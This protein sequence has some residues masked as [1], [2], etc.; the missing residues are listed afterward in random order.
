MSGRSD[1][2]DGLAGGDAH[3][4]G[5]RMRAHGTARWCR[6]SGCARV[7]VAFPQ[8]TPTRWTTAIAFSVMAGF[9]NPVMTKRDV[10]G[11]GI[12]LQD[13]DGPLGT[14]QRQR[15][16]FSNIAPPQDETSP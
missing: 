12:R 15:N 3:R 6:S 2:E 4:V 10:R 13:R 8:L 7:R 5:Q 14:P 1:A 9:T 16:R 11:G